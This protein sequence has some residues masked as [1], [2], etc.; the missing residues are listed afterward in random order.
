MIFSANEGGFLTRC[1]SHLERSAIARN[2]DHDFVGWDTSL[3]DHRKS[4]ISF[5]EVDM[6]SQAIALRTSTAGVLVVVVPLAMRVI[7]AHRQLPAR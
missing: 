4:R 2:T 3:S 5:R 7:S 1:L 6:R